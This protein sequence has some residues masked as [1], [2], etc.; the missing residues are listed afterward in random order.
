[1]RNSGKIKVGISIGDPNGIGIELL[2]KAFEDKRMF[3]F[4]TPVVFA[5]WDVLKTEQKKFS[6]YTD[7]HA[8]SLDENPHKSKLNVVSDSKTPYTIS[9]GTVSE[10]AGK[11]AIASLEAAVGALQ[12]KV[13]DVLV[14]LPI[15]KQAMQKAGFEH[16]G[17]TDFLAKKLKGESLMF[18]VHD[19]LKVALVTDHIPLQQ[20]SSA[21][22]ETL[23]KQK[24]D[25][26]LASLKRD[27]GLNKPKIALLGLN[28]HNGD[29]GVIGTEDDTLIRPVVADYFEKGHMVFGPYAADGFFGAQ[30]Y[31]SFDAVLAM[32]HDQGLIPFKTLAFGSGVNFTAGLE[33]VRTSPD[34]GTG[35]D[36]AGQKKADC[37]SFLEAL[38]VARKV[39]LNRLESQTIAAEKK[40]AS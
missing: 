14:T 33:A 13:V 40:A 20:V 36:I 10:H 22:S 28:P 29:Q 7:L 19:T 35:F 12:K 17:H 15:H 27:F 31:K 25:L 5:D 2:L 21:L 9:Y 4:F 26:L 1:M 32:Y 6:F 23:I 3:D 37:S 24:I 30:H 38:F 11:V 34:H 16:P 8:I 39:Y 18:M